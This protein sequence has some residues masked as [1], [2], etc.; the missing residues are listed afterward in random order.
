MTRCWEDPTPNPI[1]A[2]SPLMGRISGHSLLSEVLSW[3]QTYRTSALRWGPS[4]PPPVPE[5][6]SARPSCT[7]P[8]GLSLPALADRPSLVLRGSGQVPSTP[9]T[10]G[11]AGQGAVSKGGRLLGEAVPW[12][13]AA[14]EGSSPLWSRSR[15]PSSLCTRRPQRRSCHSG[16]VPGS[17]RERGMERKASSSFSSPWGA[18]RIG[19]GS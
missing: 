7:C 11:T 2:L 9:R 8:G 6:R 17:S 18:W 5:R 10:L 15:C 19:E 14:P 12:L 3:A 16:S 4:V 13:Q 1:P